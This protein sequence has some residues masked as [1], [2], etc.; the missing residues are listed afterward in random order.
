MKLVLNN[1]Q[2]NGESEWRLTR[3]NQCYEMTRAIFETGCVETRLLTFL[4]KIRYWKF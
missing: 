1:W 2:R 4:E 3:V